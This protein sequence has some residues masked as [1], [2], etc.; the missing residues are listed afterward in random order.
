MPP[1]QT[2]PFVR[3]SP[4]SRAAASKLTLTA[5]LIQTRILRTIAKA[6]NGLTCAEIEERLPLLRQSTVS[7][8]VRDLKDHGL[9]VTLGTRKT[10]RGRDADVLVVTTLGRKAVMS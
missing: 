1:T 4:T 2:V 8:R 5:K 7:A 9:V 3:T 10:P 6:P